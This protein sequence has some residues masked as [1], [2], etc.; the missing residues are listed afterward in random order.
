MRQYHYQVRWRSPGGGISVTGGT[1]N[2]NSQSEVIAF[3]RRT[4]SNIVDYNVW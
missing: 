3:I 4:Y 1:V 2:A